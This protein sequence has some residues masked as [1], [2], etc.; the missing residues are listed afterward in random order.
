[1]RQRITETEGIQLANWWKKE[2][3]RERKNS[4]KTKRAKEREDEGQHHNRE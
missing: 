4:I 1:M 2:G 3:E